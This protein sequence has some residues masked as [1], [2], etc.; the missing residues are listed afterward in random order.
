M[1][2]L[3]PEKIKKSA[4]YRTIILGE[5][6][7]R[8]EHTEICRNLADLFYLPGFFSGVLLAIVTNNPQFLTICFLQFFIWT[9]EHWS[10]CDNDIR[11]KEYDTYSR[12]LY[13]SKYSESIPRHRHP[14][15]HS[16]FPGSFYRLIYGYAPFW[17]IILQLGYWKESLPLVGVMVAGQIINDIGH[18]AADGYRPWEWAFGIYSKKELAKNK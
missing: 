4:A 5:S 12:K 9:G 14:Y 6:S 13:W 10:T 7:N 3:F 8:D 18:L 2:S 17:M 11:Y 15:S 16:I 1:Q